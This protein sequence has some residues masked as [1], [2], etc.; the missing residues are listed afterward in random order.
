MKKAF[1]LFITLLVLA[2][3]AFLNSLVALERDDHLPIAVIK[4]FDAKEWEDYVI[5]RYSGFGGN[6]EFPGQYAL[7][8]KKREHNVLCI[9]ERKPEEKNILL[10]YKQIKLYIKGIKFLTN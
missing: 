3:G 10:L 5:I 7:L 2:G 1:G 9:A 6:E 8:L 4:A